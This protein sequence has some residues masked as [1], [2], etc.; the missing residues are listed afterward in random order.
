MAEAFG[1][2]CRPPLWTPRVGWQ[3]PPSGGSMTKLLRIPRRARTFGPRSGGLGPCRA[4]VSVSTVGGAEEEDLMRRQ[5]W[6][7]Y[8]IA[9][10]I[11]AGGL[12]VL[13][14]P[15][16]HCFSRR[17]CLP[18]RSSWC[19]LCPSCAS[20]MGFLTDEPEHQR[21]RPLPDRR[22]ATGPAE[23][24]LRPDVGPSPLSSRWTESGFNDIMHIV[25]SNVFSLFVFMEMVLS[26]VAYRG[27]F[28][29]YSIATTWSSSGSVEPRGGPFK[30]SGRIARHGQATLSESTRIPTSHES[31]CWP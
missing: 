22:P 6:G 26:A 24:P 10:P 1:A 5:P 16:L 20:A 25:L 3:P 12:V 18:A 21:Q 29:R 14:V 8:A 11:I 7:L 27:W 9:L 28:R 13:G 17:S 19:S 2:G 31:S 23:R 4:P 15:V 30:A